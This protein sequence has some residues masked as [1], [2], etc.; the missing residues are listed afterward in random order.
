[1]F[2]TDNSYDL[3]LCADVFEH[4]EDSYSFLRKLNKKS[5]YFLFNIPL[6]LCLLSML[7]GNKIIKKQYDIVG[8]IHFYSSSTVTLMLELTGFEI[9][10][11]RFAKDRTRNFSAHPTF[12]NFVAMVLQFIIESINPYLSSVIM[13]DHLVVLAKRK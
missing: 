10:C 4:I 13:G 6:E 2:N 3:M 12:K 11:Q 7:Q 8:H 5:K 1:M 9:I